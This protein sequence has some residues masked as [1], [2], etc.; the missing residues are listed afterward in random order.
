MRGAC[1]I[2]NQYK[3]PDLCIAKQLVVLLK[4]MGVQV[5]SISATAQALQVPALQDGPFEVDIA[6]VLGGDG[7]ILSM[8]PELAARDI[9]VLG[10]NLGNMGF[11]SEVSITDM[12]PALERVMKRAFSIEHRMM[13]QAEIDRPV[14]T[15]TALNE[16]GL[17][18]SQQGGIVEI[19][20]L[21]GDV[22]IGSYECD[23][24]IVA[25]PTGSTAY[26]LSAGGPL[27]DPDVDCLLI[28]PV[29]AHTLYARPIVVPGNSA[30]TLTMQRA[31]NGAQVTADDFQ[32][33]SVQQGSRVRIQRAPY[34]LQFVRLQPSDFYQQLRCKLTQ[35]SC[36]NLPK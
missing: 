4:Q 18:R 5:C 13:V 29:C 35:W 32:R 8:A 30:V 2:T 27:V 36:P 34:A 25:T 24:V 11:L 19:S 6:F 12:Q 21:L 22:L 3:D 10:L 31:R 15:L 1:V 9:P 28:T 26:S 7:T 20:V 23:G 16:I 33:V 17:F 14:R